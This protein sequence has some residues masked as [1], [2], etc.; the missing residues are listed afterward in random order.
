[1]ETLIK[2]ISDEIKSKIV[3]WYNIDC[4]TTDIC[5]KECPV[6]NICDDLTKIAEAIIKERGNK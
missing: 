1:M 5:G 3:Y 2:Y 4:V 6:Y